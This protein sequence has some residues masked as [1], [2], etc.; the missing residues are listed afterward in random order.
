MGGK[1]KCKFRFTYEQFSEWISAHKKLFQS[2][3]TNFHVDIW[4]YYENEPIF[5]NN[6]EKSFEGKL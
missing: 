2:Y 6:I 5:L 1:I 4:S 3:Y